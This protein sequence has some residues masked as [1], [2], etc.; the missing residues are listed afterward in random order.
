VLTSLRTIVL[1]VRSLVSKAALVL[2]A[3]F[4]PME[5]NGQPAPLRGKSIV[6]S[7]QDAR[8][9]RDLAT[10][11]VSHKTQTNDIKL[12]VSTAGRIFSEFDRSM[13]RGRAPDVKLG[14]AG[15]SNQILNWKFEGPSIV[16]YQHFTR[17][18][19]RISINFSGE[20]TACSVTVLNGKESGSQTIVTHNLA[21][22]TQAWETEMN[23]TATSCTIHD[24]NVFGT[25]S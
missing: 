4:A 16:A 19:R 5:S 10:A 14:I 20:F 12:Y 17:G 25:D 21:R 8:T 9:Q 3:I 13:G 18:A 24:G 6:L 15:A 22:P 1:L 7:W 11:Q 2:F 23:V